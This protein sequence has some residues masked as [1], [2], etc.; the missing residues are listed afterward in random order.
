MQCIHVHFSF[1][2]ELF[3]SFEKSIS[4][5][6]YDTSHLIM[7]V[8]LYYLLSCISRESKYKRHSSALKVAVV[9]FERSSLTTGCKY[10]D[11]TW[12]L[13]VFWKTGR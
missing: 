8:S 2:F 10:S 12:N 4:I 9:A 1:P 6:K 13:L 7:Q 3:Y 5:K 11:S